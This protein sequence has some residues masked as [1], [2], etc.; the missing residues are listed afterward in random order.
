MCIV[1]KIIV[2]ITGNDSG[3]EMAAA[4]GHG[5]RLAGTGFFVNIKLHR[6]NYAN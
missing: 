1:V 5:H 3:I 4:K 6:E 2:L